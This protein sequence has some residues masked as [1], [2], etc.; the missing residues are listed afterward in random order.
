MNTKSLSVKFALTCSVLALCVLGCIALSGCSADKYES[1]DVAA[2]AFGEKIYENYVTSVIEAKREQ[3]GATGDNE[4]WQQYMTDNST[5]PTDLREQVINE[6]VA[7]IRTDKLAEQYNI[8]VSNKEIEDEIKKQKDSYSDTSAWDNYLS[9]TGQTEKSYYYSTKATLLESKM[10]KARIGCPSYDE[11]DDK[12]KTQYIKMYSG[13]YNQAKKMSWIL[14]NKENGAS[15][16]AQNIIS[17]IKAGKSFADA[18]REYSVDEDSK[19][20][21]GNKGWDIMLKDVDYT[22]I[23]ALGELNVGEISAPLDIT[24][25]HTSDSAT[26]S[27]EPLKEYVAIVTCTDKANFANDN[28]SLDNMPSEI[29]DYVKEQILD[30]EARSAYEQLSSDKLTESNLQINEMPQNA[31]YKI[32]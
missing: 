3:A 19:N 20:N 10:L 21:G 11:I 9:S 4:K 12:A 27:D 6:R 32:G 18:A 29:A 17:E 5:S 28:E 13:A 7:Q 8:S 15:D 22:A 24:E 31:S 30:I 16:K 1:G 14:L 2:E 23:Q 25:N 26:P